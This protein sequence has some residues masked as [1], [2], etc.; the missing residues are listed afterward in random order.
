[1]ERHILEAVATGNRDEVR[2]LVSAGADINARCDQ[3]ASALF[4]ACLAGDVEMVRLLLDFGA[5]P[6]LEAGEPASSIYAPKVLDLV[7]QAQFLIDWAKYT[8]VFELL[9]SRGA[10]EWGGGVPT[11][12]DTEVRSRRALEHQGW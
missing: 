2:R 4:V 3:G 7:M 8:P 1:M 9:V 6:N 5:D 12:A 11:R 10:S